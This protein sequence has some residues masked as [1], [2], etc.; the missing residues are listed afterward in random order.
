MREN[1]LQQYRAGLQ[2]WDDLFKD[3]PELKRLNGK[4]KTALDPNNIIAPGHY[5]I[6]QNENDAPLDH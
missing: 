5:G 4:I 1:H 3:A 6:S 2:S